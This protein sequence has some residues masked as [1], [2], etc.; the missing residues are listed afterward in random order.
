MGMLIR[1]VADFDIYFLVLVLISATVLDSMG[2]S[3][4]SMHCVLDLCDISQRGLLAIGGFIVLRVVTFSVA[5]RLRISR[6]VNVT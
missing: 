2:K 6:C 3:R 5:K 1:N 4:R